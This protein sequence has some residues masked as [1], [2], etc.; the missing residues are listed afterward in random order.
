MK[1]LR[2]GWRLTLGF[3]M[4]LALLAVITVVGV[5]RLQDIGSR[6][7]DLVAEDLVKER[8]SALWAAN[9]DANSVRTVA[10]IRS[11]DPAVQHYFKDQIAGTVASTSAIQKQLDDMIK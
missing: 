5:W 6:T 7:A 9:I 1:N 10:I 8:L 4:V 11:P 3:S 2:I